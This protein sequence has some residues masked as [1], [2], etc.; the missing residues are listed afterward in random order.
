MSLVVLACAVLAATFLAWMRLAT[1]GDLPA[2]T[3]QFR[4]AQM[5]RVADVKFG[6]TEAA[7]ALRLAMLVET[8]EDLNKATA[9][10]A[11]LRVRVN[12]TMGAW[13]LDIV[14]PSGQARF[15]QIEQL[16]GR[17]WESMDADVQRIEAGRKDEALASL[18]LDTTPLL[19][20]LYG[21]LEFEQ[22]RQGDLL[23]A[24]VASVE[25]LVWT[26]RSQMLMWLGA[27]LAG[28]MGLFWYTV[29]ALR[30]RHPGR[31]ES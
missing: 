11:A 3:G 15:D 21:A 25:E 9:D 26:V 18:M 2:Q 7:S 16:I 28:L 29:R 22:D 6:V 24:S 8:P 30:R 17:F 19:G 12:R 1:M 27:S 10:I 14:T 20:K 5:Q 23:S 13:R 31:S 4:I